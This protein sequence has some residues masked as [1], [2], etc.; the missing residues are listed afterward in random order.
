[1]FAIWT[2]DAAAHHTG[3]VASSITNREAPAVVAA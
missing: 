2:P 3:A 1:L